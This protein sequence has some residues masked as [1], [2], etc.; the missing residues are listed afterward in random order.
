MK[1]P[2]HLPIPIIKILH[3]LGRDINAARRRRRITVALMAERAN[4]S[5]TTISKIEKGD[6]RTSMGGYAAVLFVLGMTDR[7]K[8]LADASHDLTGRM[9]FE[10][11]LPKRI[12]IT[13]RRRGDS[14]AS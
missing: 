3:K 12:R 2:I 10:E 9:L 8:D 5:R 7:L 14:H 13:K 1:T 4:V 11:Q 6:S